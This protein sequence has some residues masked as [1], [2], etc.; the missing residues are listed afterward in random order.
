[1][2]EQYISLVIALCGLLASIYY[3]DKKVKQQQMENKDKD[4][5][6]VKKEVE[7]DT[8]ISVKLDNVLI[9]TQNLDRKI[10]DMRK[11]LNKLNTENA[12]IARDVQILF[13]RIDTTDKRLE[14]LHKEHRAHIAV[15]GKEADS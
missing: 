7:R 10:T 5:E 2:P 1:M 14:K 15:T 6:A 13:E 8:K 4:L 3:S 9:N 11:D 12:A